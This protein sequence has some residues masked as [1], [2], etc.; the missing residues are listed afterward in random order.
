MP[1]NKQP[2][3]IKDILKTAIGGIEAETKGRVYKEDVQKAWEQ[4]AGKEASR[5]STPTNIK[6]KT[7]VI[8]VD[9]PVWIYQLRLKKDKIEKRLNKLIKNKEILSIKLRAGEG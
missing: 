2:E 1:K 4:A 3:L 9:S 8:D 6:D 7:L 5:H